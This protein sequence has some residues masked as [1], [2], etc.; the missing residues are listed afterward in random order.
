M[1][2]WVK[3]HGVVLYALSSGVVK[4]KVRMGVEG[5]V[6]ISKQKT[7][8]MSEAK[9]LQVVIFFGK[10]NSFGLDSTTA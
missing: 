7:C 3:I 10:R 9:R 2:V 4:Y 6:V 1:D 8:A 5:R